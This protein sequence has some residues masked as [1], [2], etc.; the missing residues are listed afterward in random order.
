MSDVKV[1]S[2]IRALKTELRGMKYAG[3]WSQESL[4][5]G[6]PVIYLCI[7]HFLV[8]EYNQNLAETIVNKGFLMQTASDLEFMKNSIKILDE[9]VGFKTKLTVE[10]FF[11][12][13][14]VLQKMEFL[15]GAAKAI[16]SWH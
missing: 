8:L 16:R 1:Q 2:H 10:N 11:K 6:D 12:N 15:L 7:M 3:R 5:K 13:G 14:F 9:I 4:E